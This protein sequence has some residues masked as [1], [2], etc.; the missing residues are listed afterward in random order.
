MSIIYKF[1]ITSSASDYADILFL[2]STCSIITIGAI[3]EPFGAV[4]SLTASATDLSLIILYLQFPNSQLVQ[5]F[6]QSV[7]AWTSKEPSF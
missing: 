4:F 6:Q 7:A 5:S 3:S 2:S 1:K